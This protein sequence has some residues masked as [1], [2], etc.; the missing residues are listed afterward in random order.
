MSE[1]KSIHSS[2][3]PARLLTVRQF[4]ASARG[5]ANEV[6]SRLLVAEHGAERLTLEGWHGLIARRAKEPAHPT[7]LKKA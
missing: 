7:V 6:W 4:V 1:T 5:T 2:S 3:S